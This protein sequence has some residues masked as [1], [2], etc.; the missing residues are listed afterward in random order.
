[1]KSLSV[2][3]CMVPPTV[4]LTPEM[5][6]VEAA[7][8]LIAN[9]SLG[10]PVIDK[11]NHVVGWVSE[12]DCLDSVIQVAYYGQRVA[13][14]S[15]VMRSE[16]LSV[17]TED[18]ALDLVGKMRGAKPKVYPVVEDGKLLGMVSRRTILEALCDSIGKS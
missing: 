16:V 7:R 15:D 10:G 5:L 13:V 6:V 9:K 11:D 14:V 18:S 17:T 2:A 8:K 4:K 12:V 3:D 1:M